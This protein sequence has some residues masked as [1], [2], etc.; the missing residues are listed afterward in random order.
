MLLNLHFLIFGTNYVIFNNYCL[1]CENIYE[2][3][4]L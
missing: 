1:L 3:A 4:Y 2:K